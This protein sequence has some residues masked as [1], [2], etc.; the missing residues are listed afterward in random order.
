MTCWTLST[1]FSNRI[2]TMS[3]LIFV[4]RKSIMS[5]L[6]CILFFTLIASNEQLLNLILC[7]S[8]MAILFSDIITDLMIYLSTDLHS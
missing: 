3:L 4:E 8:I 7:K 5:Q 1:L 6:A 2:G